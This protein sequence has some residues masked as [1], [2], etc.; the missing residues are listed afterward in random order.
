MG[1]GAGER[2]PRAADRVRAR[3]VHAAAVWH[4]RAHRELVAGGAQSHA[5]LFETA[6]ENGCVVRSVPSSACMR[7]YHMLQACC[8][9]FVA[10]LT[11]A[12]KCTPGLLG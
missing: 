9:Y 8:M 2:G 5:A 7:G 1:G 12:A 11:I 6:H 3:G 10:L 4:A